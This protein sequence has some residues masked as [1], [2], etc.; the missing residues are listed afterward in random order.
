LTLAMPRFIAAY[1]EGD[2]H[3]ENLVAVHIREAASL[4]S[5]T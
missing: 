3:L 4:L 2:S 1:F 5:A